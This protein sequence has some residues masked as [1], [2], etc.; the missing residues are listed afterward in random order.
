VVAVGRG[1][2]VSV[3]AGDNGVFDGKASEISGVVDGS[4]AGIVIMGSGD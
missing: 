4:D 1:R 2:G 3:A